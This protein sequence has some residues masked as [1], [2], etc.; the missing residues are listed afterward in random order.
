VPGRWSMPDGVIEVQPEIRQSAFQPCWH[1][2]RPGPAA[3]PHHEGVRQRAGGLIELRSEGKVD[4][5]RV[6]FAQPAERAAFS[7]QGWNPC[8]ARFPGLGGFRWPRSLYGY[9]ARLFPALPPPKPVARS[10][11]QKRLLR[12]AESLSS[13]DCAPRLPSTL[14]SEPIAPF[15]N[16]AS[17]PVRDKTWEVL[18]T[19]V[20][21]GRSR[22]S[23]PGT[24][25]WRFS[26]PEYGTICAPARRA[27]AGVAKRIRI[28]SGTSTKVDLREAARPPF[29]AE[30]FWQR[31]AI[32]RRC[33]HLRGAG[34]ATASAQS[35]VAPGFST[36][37]SLSA[38]A[39]SQTSTASSL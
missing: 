36:A 34:Q 32:Y 31:L 5:E 4:L 7:R 25:G 23:L 30:P 10:S 22:W 1:P 16:L 15:S 20:G 18:S 14:N 24:T 9:S 26:G 21:S 12:I 35:P 11:R 6:R 37:K 38:R 2:R 39:V 27:H 17:A 3:F 13:F 33:H 8:A 28:R 19:L 29:L